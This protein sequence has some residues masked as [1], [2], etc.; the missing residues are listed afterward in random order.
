M[1]A[2]LKKVLCEWG[3]RLQQP[4]SARVLDSWLDKTGGGYAI[5]TAYANAPYGTNEPFEELFECNALAP[6]LGFK[7]WDDF[8]VREFR[9]GVRP[10]ASPEDDNV[11]AN[12][13]ESRPYNLARDVKLREKFWIKGNLYSLV[14]M[15][16]DVQLAKS[17]E[18]GIVYQAFLS[19]YSCHR[20]RVPVSGVVKHA[21]AL[22]G[23]Y[24]TIPE[25]ADP[26]TRAHRL[27]EKVDIKEW[28]AWLASVATRGIVVVDADNPALRLVGFIAIGMVEVS[29]V[30]LTVTEGQR[31]TKG[32]EIGMFHFG[33]SSHCLLFQPGVDLTG[34]PAEFGK[35]SGEVP[36]RGAV[37]KMQ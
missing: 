17:F 25:F 36:V 16:G 5:L 9:A 28:Q 26:D 11:I 10:V 27:D 6:Y 7:S 32:D 15:L 23:S 20:W 37:A 22:D 4:E 19:P 14:D 34:S 30:E 31:I 24:F 33:G 29:T 35:E 21:Y 3:P 13:C 12:A 18:G 8:F 2:E 1:I